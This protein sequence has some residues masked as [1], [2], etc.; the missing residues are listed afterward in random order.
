MNL[1]V[2]SST[3]NVQTEH[4]SFN[5]ASWKW[6][7]TFLRNLVELKIKTYFFKK[8]SEIKNKDVLFKKPSGIKN[9]PLDKDSLKIYKYEYVAYGGFL[10]LVEQTR[11]ERNKDWLSEHR[12]AQRKSARKHSC[13][14]STHACH[15]TTHAHMHVC[16]CL[17]EDNTLLF[18]H[19]T[20][21]QWTQICFY[22]CS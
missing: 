17:L 5:F 2:Q 9:S 14:A 11:R 10:Y 3:N 19:H 21:L 12:C 7:R 4:I 1:S 13:H 8:P 20:G 16:A 15:A 6:R 18:K 22:N